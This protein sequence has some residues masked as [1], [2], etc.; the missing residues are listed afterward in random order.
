MV[1]VLEF[2]FWGLDFGVWGLGFGA[3]GP[4]GLWG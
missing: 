3:Y 1:Q 2:R 4:I